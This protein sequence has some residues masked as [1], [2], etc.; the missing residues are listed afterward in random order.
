MRSLEVLIPVLLAAYLLWPRPRPFVVRLAPA[1]AL[2]A[3]LLHLWL[4]GYRWQ[5]IPLYVLTMLLAWHSLRAVAQ[6]EQKG[7]RE[8]HG[9][10]KFQLTL[11]QM[12]E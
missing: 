3:T 7:K 5:M 9:K 10:V 11:P 2:A 4:E 6:P 12:D 8:T 1:L